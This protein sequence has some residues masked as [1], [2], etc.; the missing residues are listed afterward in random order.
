[1]DPEKVA[2]DAEEQ[3]IEDQAEEFVPAGKE[4]KSELLAALKGATWKKPVTMRLSTADVMAA[5]RIA[6]R[7]GLP[8]QTL[9]SSVIHRYVTGR[10]VDVE[11]ARRVLKAA[12]P[13]LDRTRPGKKVR[14][15]RAG[16][17]RS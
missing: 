15:A 8:Y 2:L 13:A 6:E 9:L 16:K 3:E 1:M 11:Q 14:A 17:Q 5:R 10:L 4:K 12:K 7:D